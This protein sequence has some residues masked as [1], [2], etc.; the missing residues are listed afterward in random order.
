[1]RRKRIL[2]LAPATVVAVALLFL[3]SN[4]GGAFPAGGPC[5]RKTQCICCVSSEAECHCPADSPCGCRN[6][7]KGQPP[8][9]APAVGIAAPLPVGSPAVSPPAALPAGSLVSP[10]KVSAGLPGPET[11]PPE[12]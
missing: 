3:A 8:D 12:I 2:P 9:S 11:P 1:M 7:I 10:D 4:I 5:G 6:A